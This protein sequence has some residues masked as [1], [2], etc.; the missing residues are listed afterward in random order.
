M[1]KFE[2]DQQYRALLRLPCLFDPDV[3]AL[4]E[5]AAV[6]GRRVV[7][8]RVDWSDQREAK[9]TEYTIRPGAGGGG[10]A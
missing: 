9:T 6:L 2:A 7:L 10:E 5:C 8:R 1:I 4:R 3:A